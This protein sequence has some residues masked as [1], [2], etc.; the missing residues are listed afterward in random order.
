MNIQKIKGEPVGGWA[1]PPLTG[2]QKSTCHEFIV[3][4]VDN[5]RDIET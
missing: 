4:E 1:I 2:A 3:I 5:T